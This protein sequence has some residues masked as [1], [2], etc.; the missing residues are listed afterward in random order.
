MTT[1]A[2]AFPWLVF[3]ACVGLLVVVIRLDRRLSRGARSAGPRDIQRPRPVGLQQTP[4]ELKAIDDQ[5]QSGTGTR[6]RIDLTNTLN[7]L[8]RAAGLDGPQHQLPPN[9]TN[10]MIQWVVQEL[11]T[12]LELGPMLAHF[13]P[14]PTGT[15]TGTFTGTG[16]LAGPTHL[17]AD[18]AP[19]APPAA[20]P[21]G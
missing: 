5:L 12:K 17:V 18:P 7:R 1:L 4:W 3:A 16:T 9:A 13:V 10:D 11:E 6:P 8:T 21:N 14:T 2:A 15:G 20:P 19:P